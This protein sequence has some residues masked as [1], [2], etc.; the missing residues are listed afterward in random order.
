MI[1]SASLIKNNKEGLIKVQ[2]LDLLCTVSSRIKCYF[3]KIVLYKTK[4]QYILLN[5]YVILSKI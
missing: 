2:V 1:N 4:Y 5:I 3:T